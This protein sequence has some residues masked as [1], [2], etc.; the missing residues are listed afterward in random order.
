MG[1]NHSKGNHSDIVRKHRDDDSMDFPQLDNDFRD[2]YRTRSQD[3]SFKFYDHIEHSQIR[4]NSRDIHNPSIY[5]RGRSIERYNQRRSGI[6]DSYALR[7]F[8]KSSYNHDMRRGL[9]KSGNNYDMRRGGID[10]YSY[11]LTG[12]NRTNQ[13]DKTR[14]FYDDEDEGGHYDDFWDNSYNNGLNR[15]AVAPKKSRI[16]GRRGDRRKQKLGIKSGIV[17]KNKPQNQRQKNIF[18]EESQ[19]SI[20]KTREEIKNKTEAKKNDRYKHNGKRMD[21]DDFVKEED[22]PIERNKSPIKNAFYKESGNKKEIKSKVDPNK[23]IVRVTMKKGKGRPKSK[24]P[25]LLKNR[26][27][28]YKRDEKKDSYE[29]PEQLLRKNTE[30]YN[31]SNYKQFYEKRPTV[32]DPEDKKKVNIQLPLFGEKDENLFDNVRGDFI[33]LPT[34]SKYKGADKNKN[35]HGKGTE[36]FRNGDVYTGQ[37]HNGKKNGKGVYEKKNYSIYE[38]NFK[39]GR[40]EDRGKVF[41]ANGNVFEGLFKRGKKEGTGI[42]KDNE[43]NILKKGLWIDDEYQDFK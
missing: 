25:H 20:K 17:K 8:D 40:S 28:S 13:N 10:D 5:S 14:N 42:M 27:Y 7:G 31:K 26:K 41:Y 29:E 1:S 18:F 19:K 36:Y 22:K 12:L 43:G 2:N 30:F 32:K 6:K 3:G 35:P 15:S 9:D 37:F 16:F 21:F 34:G 11:N 33:K 38:G 4:N 24:N 39:D 23:S